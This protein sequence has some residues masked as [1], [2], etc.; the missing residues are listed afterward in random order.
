MTDMKQPTYRHGIDTGTDSGPVIA[1]PIL[2]PDEISHAK[3]VSHVEGAIARLSEINATH[4]VMTDD[5]A[6]LA[7]E[8]FGTDPHVFYAVQ[9]YVLQTAPAR[10]GFETAIA[11]GIS[12]R[13]ADFAIELVAGAIGRYWPALDQAP[14]TDAATHALATEL[15]AESDVIASAAFD[16]L[17]T[18]APVNGGPPRPRSAHWGPLDA[19]VQKMLAERTGS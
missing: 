4:L 19:A 10:F 8:L 16:Y 11:S 12:R 13:N 9:L 6:A 5:T 15:Y 3:L 2:V 18:L 17:K 1:V 7:E 14:L